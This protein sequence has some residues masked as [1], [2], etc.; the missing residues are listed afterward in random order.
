MRVEIL[1]SASTDIT[2]AAQKYDQLQ[3]GLGDAIFDELEHKVAFLKELPNLF[4][5]ASSN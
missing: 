1:D 2:Q 3:A 5:R 4:Q